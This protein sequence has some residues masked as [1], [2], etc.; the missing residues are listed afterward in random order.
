MHQ[1][2]V[3]NC[4]KLILKTFVYVLE[5]PRKSNIYTEHDISTIEQ[6]KF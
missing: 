4:G 6:N 5:N 1:I 2:C 3:W